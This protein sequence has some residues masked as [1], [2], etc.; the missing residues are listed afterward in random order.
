MVL[1]PT[2]VE[3]L[4]ARERVVAELRQ[5]LKLD[6]PREGVVLR[7][8]I[9]VV[10]NNGERI[11]AKHKGAAFSETKT[12]REVD[13]AKLAMLEAAEAIAEEWV[14][15]MRL[16]HVLDRLGN[17]TDLRETGKVI[18]A[19]VE[20]VTREGSEEFVDSKDARKAIG[21]KAA[22]ML[23]ARVCKVAP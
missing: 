12:P 11:I 13:P 1:K 21:K 19:M 14:T 20:D 23:K 5:R 18:A 22:T 8:L 17:P 15:E 6:K 16:T 9:E 4:D 7:P 2:I 10:K 3:D